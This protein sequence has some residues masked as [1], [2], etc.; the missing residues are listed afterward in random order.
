MSTILISITNYMYTIFLTLLCKFR[1]SYTLRFIDSSSDFYNSLA[2]GI[3]DTMPADYFE[4]VRRV[5]ITNAFDS[6]IY[7]HPSITSPYNC[8]LERSVE[9]LRDSDLIESVNGFDTLTWAISIITA[10]AISTLI[11]GHFKLNGFMS[12]GSSGSGIW[13]VISA[14]LKNPSAKEIN[15][16][17]R[18]LLT[19][20]SLFAFLVGVCYFENMIKSD[21][22][23]IY[24]P[25]VYHKLEDISL[26][27]ES[28]VKAEQSFDADIMFKNRSNAVH[29]D[30]LVKEKKTRSIDLMDV[31]RFSFS[32]SPDHKALLAYTDGDPSKVLCAFKESAMKSL[33]ETPHSADKV[34]NRIG[35]ICF[36]SKR[37]IDL[38]SRT[39]AQPYS[40]K[41]T[42]K[43]MF[44][45]YYTYARRSFEMSLTRMAST[46]EVNGILG[47]NNVADC[48]QKPPK[49]WD[50]NVPDPTALK[51]YR[52]SLLTLMVPLALA[53]IVLEYE[54]LYQSFSHPPLVIEGMSFL[55]IPTIPDQEPLQSNSNIPVL[56]PVPSTSKNSDQLF[57][58]RKESER[59]K[60]IV[61]VEAVEEC[62]EEFDSD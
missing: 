4:W 6:R 57:Y 50:K 45:K 1:F 36:H 51:F 7:K 26:D 16:V 55:S 56:E 22:I 38:S 52:W 2:F 49:T 17:S 25:S 24:Q 42:A 33:S 18:L 54:L 20:L 32:G 29:Q 3:V 62:I 11:N 5:G 14:L 40:T 19:L 61:R 23:L 12:K 48:S 53:L 27:S 34:Y 13:T 35:D 9:G 58:V 46:G 28:I 39:E 15:Y 47:T 60:S 10:L 31:Y 44:E 59:G 30:I 8:S 37:I 43:P 21:Q 41:F